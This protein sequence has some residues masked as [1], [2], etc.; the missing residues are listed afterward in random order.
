M[1]TDLQR[2][3]E[4]PRAMLIEAGSLFRRL[5]LKKGIVLVRPQC[6]RQQEGQLFVQG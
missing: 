4:G 5:G 2:G 1:L 6:R 3:I